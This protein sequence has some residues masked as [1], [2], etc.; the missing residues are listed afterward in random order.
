METNHTTSKLVQHN[1]I[2]TTQWKQVKNIAASSDCGPK[3]MKTPP[4]WHQE[5]GA[6]QAH[7]YTVTL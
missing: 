6:Q 2:S 5:S 3:P 4:R 1:E 7:A